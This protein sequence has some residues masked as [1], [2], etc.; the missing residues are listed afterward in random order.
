MKTQI[1][2]LILCICATHFFFAQENI[3]VVALHLPVRNSLTFN[4]YAINPAFSFVREQN[5]YISFFNK[6]EWVQFDDAP[7]TYLVSYNG[8]FAE[9]IG[10]GLGLFQQNYGVLTTFGGVL[11]FA[12]N[13]RLT[14]D[15]NLTFGLN[16]AAYNSGINSG[17]VITNFDDPSLQNV[18]KNLLLTINP[19]INYGIA[20]I[21]FG[22]SINNLVAYNFK[23]STLIEDN[24]ESGIQVHLMHTSYVNSRGFFDQSKFSGLIRSEFKQDETIVSAMA[25]LTVPKGIWAQAGYNS[26]YGISG[27][28]G[29]NIT[30]QMAIEYNFEKA[31]GDL[32][33][34]GPSHDLTLA[35]RFKN[36]ETYYY[37]SDDEVVGLISTSNKKRRPASKISKNKAEENRKLVAQR[38]AQILAKQ[39]E[40]KLLEEQKAREEAET[41]AKLLEEQKAREEAQTQAKL[42]EEQ[43]AR[44]EAEAQAQLL[45]EQKAREEAEAQAKLL[46]EQKAREERITN[47][48]DELGKAMLAL[49]KEAEH[50]KSDQDELLKKMEGIVEIKNQDL[51]VL[52]EENDLSEQ[53]I[54]V[55]P[56]PFK[57]V[58]EENSRL[59]NIITSFDIAIKSR[60]L[61]IKELK[62]LY[63]DY[64]KA[65]TILLDEVPLHY[66]NTITRL[67]AEQIQAIQ[68]RLSLELRLEE[69]KVATEFERN[70][71]IKRAVFDNE[72]ERSSNDRLMLQNIKV[73]TPIRSQS[74]ELEDFDFG[75]EQSS[76]IQIL[77]N[78]SYADNGY[79][80]VIAVHSD[81]EKRNDFV[82]KVV[83]SGL[84]NVD[85]FY[86]VNT[87]KY[88]IYNGKFDS[89]QAATEALK[90]V[91]NKPYNA[92][93]SLIKIEN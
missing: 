20:F 60:D 44:E 92:K 27:G 43:K 63:E 77:K 81:V 73:A 93:M 21:D 69:I 70:R 83:A 82:T 46:E 28:I 2:V 17:N 35:Y 53:G 51:K 85:F 86:D 4:R 3:G 13:V 10:A 39:E 71:R 36:K 90:S 25:M 8:R 32:T 1:L 68:S 45:E 58:T 75:E 38:K 64:F 22:V 48:R 34:F 15:S 66:K 74:Y 54:A 37:S 56:I 67:E 50:L 84:T 30:T 26:V 23:S 55:A 57:S 31:I 52:K 42:L 18:P 49:N 88:Y 72:D 14:R 89:I 24:P 12:Y 47:P 33:D 65:D 80:L 7:N 41:Q 5:K 62:S 29:L 59:N 79:Y 76:N 91:K 87:S 19:G 6:R 61:K 9:N 78:V 16:V 11:N 40:T